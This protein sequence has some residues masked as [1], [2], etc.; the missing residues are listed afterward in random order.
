MAVNTRYFGLLPDEAGLRLDFPAG[1]PAFEDEKEFVLLCVPETAPLVFLQSTQ[2]PELCFIA[3]PVREISPDYELVM[4]AEDR[5]VLGPAAD[6]DVGNMIV[7]TIL[8]LS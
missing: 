3:A 7:L 5:A 8:T 6:T 4:S 2:T 1:I